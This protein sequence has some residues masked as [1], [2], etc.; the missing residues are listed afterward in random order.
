MRWQG[1]RRGG[2]GEGEGRRER[3]GDEERGDEEG[4]GNA[5]EKGEM[6]T[7]AM[8]VLGKRDSDSD[9]GTW[10]V[11]LTLAEGDE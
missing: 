4:D 7:T 2:E 1:R 5:E 3:R 9:G 10:A 6:A 8:G 11:G